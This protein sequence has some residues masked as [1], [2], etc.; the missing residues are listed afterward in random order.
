MNAAKLIDYIR[1]AEHQGPHYGPSKTMFTLPL[2]RQETLKACDEIERM[3]KALR[4]AAGKLARDRST[5]KYPREIYDD[6]ITEA[7]DL[8]TKAAK[9]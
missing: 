1:R 8:I 5:G 4:L 2:F 3:E 9:E 7:A 6:L